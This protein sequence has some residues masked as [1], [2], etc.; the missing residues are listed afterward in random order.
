MQTFHDSADQVTKEFYLLDSGVANLAGLRANPVLT[1]YMDTAEAFLELTQS[2]IEQLQLRKNDARQA[3]ADSPEPGAFD[4][5]GYILSKYPLLV[6]LMPH[7]KSAFDLMDNESLDHLERIARFGG[8]L[9][10]LLMVGSNAVELSKM[11]LTTELAGELINSGNAL[12]SGGAPSDH[13]CYAA[14]MEHLDYD[15]L[16]RGM[17]ASEAMLLTEGVIRRLKMIT[18]L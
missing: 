7:F 2:L 18:E 6:I 15:E 12:L 5:A 16:N 10:V 17:D 8:R 14:V 4:E 3:S 1:R 13:T 11:Q 9:G